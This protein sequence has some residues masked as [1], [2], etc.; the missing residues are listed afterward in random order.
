MI[1]LNKHFLSE[2]KRN[3]DFSKWLEIVMLYTHI[4]FGCS[5]PKDPLYVGRYQYRY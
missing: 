3:I 5:N 2:K 4:F 1:Q